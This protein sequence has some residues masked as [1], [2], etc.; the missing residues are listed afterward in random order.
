MFA[1][2]FSITRTIFFS[3]QVRK[4]LVIK[5]HFCFQVQMHQNHL[6][7]T[8]WC[9]FGRFLGVSDISKGPPPFEIRKKSCL[10]DQILRGCRKSKN[11]Q[12]LKVTA[13]CLMW[14]RKICQDASFLWPRF[15]GPFTRSMYLKVI[16]FLMH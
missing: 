4:I 2:L 11:K 12:I 7:P 6:G 14:N 15:S 8:G 16:G 13:L 5:Y 9:D 3:Q 1:N 10:N